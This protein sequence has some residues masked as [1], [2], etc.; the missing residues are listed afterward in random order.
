MNGAIVVGGGVSGLTTAVLLAERGTD[1]RVWSR[2]DDARTASGISGGLCWPYRIEP[3]REA[4][5]WAVRSFRNFA[6]LAEQPALTGVRLVRGTLEGGAAG[7]V[8]PEWLSLIGSPPRTPIVDMLAYLPY[9]RGRL[10]AA[11]GTVERREVSSL[12]EAAAEAPVVIDCAGLGARELAGDARL[13]AVRGQIVV[14]ENPGVEEWY[15]SSEA[16]AAETTYVLPQP[17]GLLLGGTADEDAEETAPDPAL[18]RAIVERCARVHPA[19]AEARITE[20]RVGLRPYRPRVRL[21]AERLPGGALCVHNYGHGGA[22]VTVSWGCA[23]RA[24]SLLNA[25]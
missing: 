24:L 1:V 18:T 6:W 10:A 17:Y 8:P 4:L 12:A 25:Q 11:G 21:E 22:G 20:V 16:G 15:L 19:I 23:R 13:R 9:L 2:D 5:E 3:Q 14:V 7:T